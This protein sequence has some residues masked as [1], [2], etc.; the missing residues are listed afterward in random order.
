[1]SGSMDIEPTRPSAGTEGAHISGGAAGGDHV[2][3]GDHADGSDREGRSLGNGVRLT[4][5]VAAVAALGVF[6]GWP[7]LLMVMAIIVS[8]ALHE[9]GHFMVARWTGMKA[10]EFFIGFGPRLWSL[11]RGETEY[12]IKAIPAGAYVRIIG[13]HNL[14]PVDPADEGRS[15]RSKSYPRRLA[16]VLAGPAMNLLIGFVLLF[17]IFAGFGPQREDRWTV[18]RVLENSAADRA[19]LQRGDRIVSVDGTE[20]PVFGD[21]G[22]AIGDRSGDRVDIIVERDGQTLSLP[23]TIGWRLGHTAAGVVPPLEPLDRVL[24]VDGDEVQ[25]YSQFRSAMADAPQGT[26]TVEFERDGY[27]YTADVATPVTLP[28]D[29]A[30][31]AGFLGI[32]PHV[33]RVPESPLSALSDSARTFGEVV[34]GSV[35]GMTHFFS[36]TGLSRYAELVFSTPPTG[37]DSGVDGASGQIKPVESGTPQ[38]TSIDSGSND[39]DRVLS[40]LGVIRLG[41]QAADGGAV[42]FIFL[43]LTVNIFLAL[44]NLVP[45]LPFDGGHAAVAT[46]E[47]I[48]GA[49]TGRSYRVDMAKLMPITYVVV[50]LLVGLG[51]S[52]MYLDIVSP[53]Q[54][55]FGP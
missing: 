12:G 15:Y 17:V 49:V 25:S 4:L 35:A 34:S 43:L 50:F 54:N 7:I 11:R 37:T 5:L 9:L 13:M 8:I 2:D 18:G 38:A 21:L 52:S 39:G 41:S 26:V 30:S 33:P 48:H 46:Y 27:S 23:T 51:L 16:V 6:G 24:S 31:N 42:T 36:P 10:T 19:G 1:M 3:G 29:G 53:A 44:I 14:E 47:A 20:V 28:A 55:P 45:L 32:G 22:Y 40:I